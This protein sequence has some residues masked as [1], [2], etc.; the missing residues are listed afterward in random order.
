MRHL[1]ARVDELGGS[2]HRAGMST[3]TAILEAN[4]DG[5]VHLPVPEELRG[6]K[7][8]VVAHLAAVPGDIAAPVPGTKA[9]EWARRARG[10]VRLASGES[11]DDARMAHYSA[12][13]GVKA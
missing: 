5:S 4:P 11:A 7:I 2:V 3:V 12:K 10:S 8:K 13:Y 6:G 9:R 1:P